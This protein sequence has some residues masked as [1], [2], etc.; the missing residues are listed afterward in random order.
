MTQGNYVS[1]NGLK[2]YYEIY[3]GTEHPLVLLHGGFGE[4]GMFGEILPVLAANRQVIEVELQGHGHTEDIDRPLSFE[5][6][7]RQ[8]CGVGRTFAVRAGRC[9]GL[10]VGRWRCAVNRHSASGN[11]T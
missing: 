4:I 10:F 11:R 2:L 9:Y 6:D 5:A 1:I 7:D 8:C 3:G